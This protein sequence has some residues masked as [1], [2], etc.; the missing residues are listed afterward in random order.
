MYL[1]GYSE[2]EQQRLV[3]QALFLE[4]L[5]YSDIDLSSVKNLLEIGTGV[6]AQ[7]AILLNR[8][9]NLHITGIDSSIQQLHTADYYLNKKSELNNRFK[10]SHMS[11]ETMEFEDAAF[12]GV[13]LCWVLEHVSC[14]KQVLKEAFRVLEP[15]G[16]LYASEVFNST[17]FTHPDTPHIRYFWNQYNLFQEKS[18]GDPFVGAKLGNLL[19]S[20]GFSNICMKTKY[21]HADNRDPNAKIKTLEYW[22]ELLLS[23]APNLLQSGLITTQSI[24]EVKK[25]FQAIA[26]NPE[27]VFFCSFIQAR[28]VKTDEI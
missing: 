8:F 17:F 20:A 5:V 28:A 19:T 26:N 9:P 3:E 6:G 24:D 12:G 1:H 25:E 16:V 13:F 2:K 15:G 23:A 21:F 7:S 18:G 11:A 22:T 10:L 4:E 14:P 27:G